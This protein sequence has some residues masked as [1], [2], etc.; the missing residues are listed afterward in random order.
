MFSSRGDSVS[1]VVAEQVASE[2]I[3][4]VLAKV[5]GSDIVRDDVPGD[6]GEQPG[7][8]VRGFAG[9]ELPSVKK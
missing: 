2:R 1:D 3:D 4:D 9:D 8:G 5:P 6:A 7:G